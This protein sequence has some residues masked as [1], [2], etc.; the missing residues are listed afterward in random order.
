MPYRQQQQRQHM[1][2]YGGIFK[3]EVRK[4]MLVVCLPKRNIQIAIQV[5]VQEFQ[6]V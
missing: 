1:A 5:Q 3:D 4:S 6:R 2:G